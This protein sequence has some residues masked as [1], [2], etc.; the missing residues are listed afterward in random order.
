MPDSG[1]QSIH[2]DESTNLS[3]LGK[4]SPIL[5]YFCVYNPSLSQSEENTK[6]QILYYTAKKAVSADL[7]IKQVGLA[8]ALVNFTSTFSPSHPTQNV[9]SQKNRMV[10]LQPE[11][12]FWMHMCVELGIHRRQIKDS[13]GKEKL[14]TEYLDSQLNDKALEAVLKIGYEQFKLLNGTFSSILYGPEHSEQPTRQRTRSLMHAIEEFFSDWIWKWDFDRL[15]LMCFTALFNGVPIQSILRTN[16]LKIHNLEESIKSNFEQHIHHLFI[17]QMEDGSLVYKS[18]DLSIEDICALRKYVIKRVE[19]HAKSEKRKADIEMTSKKNSNSKVSGFK[20]FTKSLPQS[21]ILSY[22]SLGGGS[23][24]TETVSSSS[25]TESNS[26]TST[27]DIPSIHSGTDTS[28]RKGIYL[29]GLIES[30]AIGMNG[31]E[32]SVTKS[33]LVRVYISSVINGNPTYQKDKELHDYYLLV[34]K[35]KSNLVWNFLL[36]ATS[37]TEAVLSSPTFYT[38]LEHYM[39]EKDLDQLTNTLIEDISQMQ[40]KK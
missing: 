35:H 23:R 26:T 16:Y 1:N 7:K 10:F 12:G 6:D 11:P 14:V 36:P 30:T 18:P 29:T 24:S 25:I 37:E 8:Q 15:D 22:F 31:E 20:Q 9:H 34:Y 40:K 32:R 4:T 13:K 17:L 28:D 21:H 3:R 38:D 2:K 39:K 33:N 5:S 19:N 27:A